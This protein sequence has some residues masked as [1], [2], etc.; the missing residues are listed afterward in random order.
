MIRRLFSPLPT[1]SRRAG[2]RTAR[3]MERAAPLAAELRPVRPGLAG[4]QYRPQEQRFSDHHK[5]PLH[6]G[7]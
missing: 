2:G 3:R 6:T 1:S 4:G 7:Y 5:K